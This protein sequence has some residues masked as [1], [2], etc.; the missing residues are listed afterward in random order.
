MFSFTAMSQ[1]RT[2]HPISSAK[3]A[4]VDGK[5]ELL[6]DDGLSEGFTVNLLDITGKP[7]Y[8]QFYPANEEG[9][10]SIEIPV[11][12]LRKGIYIVQVVGTSGK[13]KTLKLQRN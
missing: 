9:C 13:T 7:I 2:T 3:I 4:G 5:A 1:D 8:S 10:N 6:F 12:N 11:E